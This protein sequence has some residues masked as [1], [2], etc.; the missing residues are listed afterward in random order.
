[1]EIQN[2]RAHFTGSWKAELDFFE[3]ENGI[4]PIHDH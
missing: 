2:S 1:M 3:M 4:G